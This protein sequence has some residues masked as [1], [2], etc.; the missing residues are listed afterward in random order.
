MYISRYSLPP[1]IEQ[2]YQKAL[3]TIGTEALKQTENFR[4]PYGAY[5]KAVT[6][7]SS[8]YGAGSFEELEKMGIDTRYVIQSSRTLLSQ[9][10][11]R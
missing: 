1:E 10:R 8:P 5:V 7:K 11:I 6:R 2:I 9:S 4:V 3:K